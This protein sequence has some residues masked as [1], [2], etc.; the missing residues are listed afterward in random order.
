MKKFELQNMVEVPE[1]IVIAA[2]EAMDRD[3]NSGFGIVLQAA[4]EYKA[5]DMT[6]VFILDRVNMDIMCVA[7]ETFGKKLH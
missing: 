3:D 1:K 6:P 5:A 7:L 4:R 2:W